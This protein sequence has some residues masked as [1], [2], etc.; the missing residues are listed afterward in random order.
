MKDSILIIRRGG[1]FLP[2]P[3]HVRVKDY[4][5]DIYQKHH[6]DIHEVWNHEKITSISYYVCNWYKNL[7]CLSIR[8]TAL[9]MI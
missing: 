1:T 9:M 6:N 4:W 7:L 2:T 5:K 3:G 8:S